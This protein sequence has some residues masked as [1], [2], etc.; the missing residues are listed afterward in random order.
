LHAYNTYGFNIN[1]NESSVRKGGG[2]LRINEEGIG[3]MKEV[4]IRDNFLNGIQRN[5]LR[6]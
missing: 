2:R 3:E 4:I 6:H 1:V 5:A